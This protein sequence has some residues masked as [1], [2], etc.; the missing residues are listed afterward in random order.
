[1]TPCVGGGRRDPVSGF[2]YTAVYRNPDTR[3]L[4]ARVS[5]HRV[6]P[7]LGARAPLGPLPTTLGPRGRPEGEFWEP[8]YQVKA[9]CVSRAG[10]SESH[11]L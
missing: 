7:L 5:E 6:T 11:K 9:F 3:R 2:L 10:A 8:R 4:L 1:M